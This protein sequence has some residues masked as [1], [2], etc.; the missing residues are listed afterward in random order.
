MFDLNTGSIFNPNILTSEEKKAFD[1]IWTKKENSF[2]QFTI[3]EIKLMLGTVDLSLITL[4]SQKIAESN[5][6]NKNNILFK[7][8]EQIKLYN[9]I[10]PENEEIEILIEKENDKNINIILD[11]YIYEQYEEYY[12]ENYIKDPYMIDG[13]GAAEFIKSQAS[14][15]GVANIIK[16]NMLDEELMNI[17]EHKACRYVY[18]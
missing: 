2:N 5:I 15:Y 13:C 16:V 11:E 1:I 7:R 17:R 3:Q 4:K 14:I 6:N 10:Y 12:S 9:E 18:Y 8:D